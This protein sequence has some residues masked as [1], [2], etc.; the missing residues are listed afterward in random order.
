MLVHTFFIA[1][2][3]G[4]MGLLC[5]VA[6]HDLIESRLGKTISL[7]LGIFW[8]I[9]LLFQLFVYSPKLWL[10]KPFETSVHVVFI[11]VWSYLTVVFFWA[12]LVQH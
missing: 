10:G 2:T 12:A 4:M 8:G 9:R 5:L 1:L 7:G 6:T 3:V 11:L